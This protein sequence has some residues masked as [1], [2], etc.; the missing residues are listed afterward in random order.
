MASSDAGATLRRA[1]D[2][3][4]PAIAALIEAVFAEYPGV[5]FVPEEMPELEAPATAFARE[6]GELHVAER[7]GRVVGCVGWTPSEGGVEL[8]KLYVARAERRAGLGAELCDVVERAAAR[9]GVR[10]LEL[11]SDTRFETAHAFYERRGWVRDGR[12][13]ALGDRSATVELHFRKE[14]PA[15]E[16]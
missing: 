16:V 3:D 10:S 5:M 4:G 13:R 6:G 9:R 15:G 2:A 11:W 14:V 8:K 7:G 1:R 12:T